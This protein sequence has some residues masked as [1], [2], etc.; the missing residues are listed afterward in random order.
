[1][2]PDTVAAAVQQTQLRV[3]GRRDKDLNQH[4]REPAIFV[5]STSQSSTVILHC[6]TPALF[7]YYWAELSITH[8][9]G[10]CIYMQTDM[11]GQFGGLG[12]GLRGYMFIYKVLFA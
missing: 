7:R 9:L 4:G 12:S 1:M 5:R 3:L 10:S 6:C 2:K 8:G 11:S